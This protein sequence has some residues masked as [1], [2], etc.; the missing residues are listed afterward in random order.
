MGGVSA[1]LVATIALLPPLALT[2][3]ACGRGAVGRR[4]AAVQLASSIGVLVLVVMTFAF[5]QASSIDLALT[6]AILTLPAN[7][8]FAVFVER[9]L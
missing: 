7:L 5:G 9:W 1:W 6:L 4:L 3:I 8:L 2:V